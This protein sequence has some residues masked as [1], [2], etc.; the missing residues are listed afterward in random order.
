VGEPPA[1]EVTI[2]NVNDN[3]DKDF[4]GG[5]VSFHCFSGKCTYFLTALSHRC[6]NMANGKSYKSSTIPRPTNISV[7][8]ELFLKKLSRPKHV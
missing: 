6:V 8:P 2:C 3:I 7:W 5:L 4:L 1:V